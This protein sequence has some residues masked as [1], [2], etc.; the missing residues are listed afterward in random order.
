MLPEPAPPILDKAAYDIQYSDKNHQKNIILLTDGMVDI[1]KQPEANRKEWRRIV[2]EVLPKLK[3]S[4]YTVH[5]I[6]LSKNA[7]RDLM[8]RLSVAT[9]GVAETAETADELMKIFLSAFDAAVPSEQVALTD[10][11]FVIDSSVEELTALIFRKQGG[12]NTQIVTPDNQTWDQSTKNADLRWH[13]T[14]QYDLITITQPLEGEWGVIGEID[15]DSRITVVSNLNLRLKPLPNNVLKGAELD[16]SVLLQEDGATITNTEFLSLMDVRAELLGGASADALVSLWD[17]AIDAQSPSEGRYETRLPPLDKEGLYQLEIS[18]D[19]KTFSRKIKRQI[20][21]RQPF[22][23]DVREQFEDGS[24]RYMLTVNAYQDGINY[25]KTQ[26]I[27]AVTKPSGQ[28]I[29]R[30]LTVSEL[31]TWQTLVTPSSEGLYTA[32]IQ[33]KGVTMDDQVFEYELDP[34]SFTYSADAGM[35]E[36]VPEVNEPDEK[37]SSEGETEAEPEAESEATPDYSADA[38]ENPENEESEGLPS[39][40]L[41]AA[42]G[43]GNVLLAALGYFAFKKIMSGPKSDILDELEEQAEAKTENQEGDVSEPTSVASAEVEAELE[44]EVP[45]DDEDEEEPPMEDLDPDVSDEPVIEPESEP[46]PEAESEPETSPEPESETESEPELFTETEPAEA[47]PVEAEQ[48]EPE[49]ELLEPEPEAS[50]PE[51]ADELDTGQELLDADESDT[52]LDD[53]DE[54]AMAMADAESNGASNTEA[55]PEDD[56][57]VSAMLKAQGLDLAEEELDDAISSLIDDLEE[58]DEENDK[59]DDKK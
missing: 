7:D 36:S 19:G 38:A 25:S 48:D 29:V 27:A 15:P 47:E 24:V 21:L 17:Q 44:A 13:R 9:D 49:T 59:D 4:G 1:D 20:T 56:D 35:V 5:T 41:Y 37:V 57:M 54:M 55:A 33:V 8:D 14:D 42:L 11:A 51:A 46:E 22:G 26:V 40:A 34:M 43:V 16:I 50:E 28:K 18:V 6:A 2:D 52:E 58:E 23:A 45:E 3:E 30:P 31:D 32:R 10:N 53:L 39:W 12:D